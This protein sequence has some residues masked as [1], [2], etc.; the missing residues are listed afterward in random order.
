[1]SEAGTT[2]IRRMDSDAKDRSRIVHGFSPKSNEKPEWVGTE[3]EIDILIS[4]D[5]L[6]EGQNLQD[7][8]L[9]GEL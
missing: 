7:L 6:S 8:R 2:R 1:M 3:K 5:V 4:T 9:S